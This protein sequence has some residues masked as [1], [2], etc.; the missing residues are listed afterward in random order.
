MPSDAKLG[1]RLLIGV[2]LLCLLLAGLTWVWSTVNEDSLWSQ[3]ENR[4]REE[5]E[6]ELVGKSVEDVVLFLEQHEAEH[7]QVS[8]H[9]V[10]CEKRI[11]RG[12]DPLSYIFTLRY[13]LSLHF[14]QGILA[15]VIVTEEFIGP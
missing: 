2:G 6:N 10:F 8:D 15:E 12:N 9:Y 5:L 3:D 4:L 14:E 13:N 7:I 1:P 11:R